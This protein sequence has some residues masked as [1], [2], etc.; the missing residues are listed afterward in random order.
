[1]NFRLKEFYGNNNKIIYYIEYEF[2]DNNGEIKTFNNAEYFKIDINSNKFES[3]MSNVSGFCANV[4][5]RLIEDKKY[6]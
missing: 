5:T 2:K 3:I 6:N 1:M 4:T